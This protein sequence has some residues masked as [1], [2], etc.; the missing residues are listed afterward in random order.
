VSRR[1]AACF[2][3]RGNGRHPGDRLGFVVEPIFEENL[4]RALAVS[5]GDLMIF[6]ETGSQ[7]LPGRK[8]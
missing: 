2:P 4:R 1:R 3:A 5:R 8:W 7:E 6:I